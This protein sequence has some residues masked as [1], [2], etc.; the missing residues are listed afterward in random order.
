MIMPIRHHEARDFRDLPATLFCEVAHHNSL[1][2]NRVNGV[3]RLS[4]LFSGL[5]VCVRAC[6]C[7]RMRAG[8]EKSRGC[9][10]TSDKPFK[11]N[12]FRRATSVSQVARKSRM[13]RL[14]AE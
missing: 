8:I 12:E 5:R 13:L 3:A 2:A 11:I 14:E 9:R 1:A 7:V 10:G 6:A 4:R